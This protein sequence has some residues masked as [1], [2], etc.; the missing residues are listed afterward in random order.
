M[1][2]IR[3]INQSNPYIHFIELYEQGVHKKQNFIESACIST[4]NK[5]LGLV[6]SRY[7]NIKYIIDDKWLFFSNYDSNKANDIKSHDQIS[8]C[9]FWDKL[10]VQIRLKAKIKKCSKKISDEH[11]NQR[12]YKKNA[13]AISSNQSKVIDSYETVIKNYKEVINKKKLL[14]QR[15]SYW[16]GYQFTPFSFEFW[17]GHESRINKRLV[18]KFVNEEWVEYTLEP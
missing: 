16:G 9:I 2:D 13:L 11:F 14:S 10:D 17:Q 8:V 4:F 15:P 12:S 1:I 5:K 7:V 6:D 18:Y 3:N